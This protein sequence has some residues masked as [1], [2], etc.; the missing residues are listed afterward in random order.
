MLKNKFVKWALKITSFMVIFG[1]VL[2]LIQPVFVPKYMNSSTTIIKGYSHLEKDSLDVLFLGPSQ[3]FCSVDAGSLTENYGIS[4]Y[5]FGATGQ[6]LNIT[7]YYF[8]MACKTQTPKMVMVEISLIFSGK[9][10]MDQSTLSWNYATTPLSIEKFKSLNTVLEG[11]K[12]KT[13]QYTL[14]PISLFHDRWN[15]LTKED[16]SYVL[17]PSKYIDDSLRGFLPRDHVE[18]HAIAFYENNHSLKTIPEENKEAVLYIAEQCKEKG[19]KLVFFKT[20]VSDWTK[21]D[22]QSVKA[23]MDEYGLEYLELNEALEEIG[24]DPATDFYNKNH[25][26]TSGAGKTTDYLSEILKQYLSSI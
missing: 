12:I 14:F 26:N 9:S 7:P 21:G 23:L 22:S 6:T 24:I 10:E 15:A 4:S 16:V 3:M 2:A 20:P 18:E 25:L 17:N 19:M 8:D 1:V 13:L 5:A 11:D